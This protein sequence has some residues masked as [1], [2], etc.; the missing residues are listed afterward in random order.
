MSTNSKFWSAFQQAAVS[1][2]PLIKKRIRELGY[3]VV[4]FADIMAIARDQFGQ[5]GIGIVIKDVEIARHESFENVKKKRIDVVDVIVTILAYHQ[6][7]ETESFRV[8]GQAADHSDKAVAKATTMALKTWLRSALMLEEESDPDVRRPEM[9]RAKPESGESDQP[10]KATTKPGKSTTKPESK[11]AKSN[12]TPESISESE[13]A[14]LKAL[15]LRIPDPDRAEK[16]IIE[17]RNLFKL[18][19]LPKSEWAELVKKISSMVRAS[20]DAATGPKDNAAEL[21][22]APLGN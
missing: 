9:R 10:A 1:A 2:P 3:D 20:D 6:S 22:E 7:G 13:L 4:L 5:H 16:A 8:A 15:L 12:G 18:S 19:D 21:V 17:K 14:E 11:P